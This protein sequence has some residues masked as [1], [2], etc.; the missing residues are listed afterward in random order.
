MFHHSQTVPAVPPGTRAPA[1]EELVEALSRPEAYPL[2]PASV[3]VLETH[4][5][6]LFFADQRVYKVKKAVDLGFLDH[7][8]LEKRRAACRDEVRLNGRLAPDVYLRVVPITRETD[9]RIV[10][11]GDGDLVEV[12]VEMNRLPAERML[13][14]LLD[15]G[16]I[17]SELVHEL[18]ELL[19]LFHLW[20]PTGLGVDEHGA[21]EAVRRLVLDNLDGL[22]PFVGGPGEEAPS[23]VPVLSA[24][25]HGWLRERAVAF[26]D[27][28]EV[29]MARRVEEGRIREGHGDL[30]AGN[31]CVLDDAIVAYDCLEFSRA[32]RCG[33]AACDLAFLAMDLDSR[34]FRAFSQQL[35]REYARIARDSDAA[36][37][38]DFYKTYRALVR[39]K[40]A[41]LSA[42]QRAPDDPEREVW[43]RKAV[44]SAQLAASYELPPALVL[45]CGLPATGKSTLARDLARPFEAVVLR[46]DVVRKQL[47]GMPPTDRPDAGET[48]K[49]YAPETSDEVHRRLLRRATAALERGRSV[50]VDATFGER[51]RRRRFVDAASRLGHPVVV[52]HVTAD[53]ATVRERLEARARDRRAV[54]DADWAVHQ[55]LLARFE[56]PDELPADALVE[57]TSPHDPDVARAALIER[58]LAQVRSRG[59][60]STAPLETLA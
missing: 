9:G 47:L 20:A 1:P 10:L 53:E 3:D 56:A 15:A 33:D 13:D 37:L 35:V 39:A 17:D 21:P 28:H 60:S 6:L 31:L 29:L 30:H 24:G 5:S 25:L 27:R 42:R 49:L 51:A 57:L 38:V 58:L 40:V 43:R 22:K 48:V 19:A 26:L 12:A 55:L 18:S 45:T 34:G 4:I 36:Y 14:R 32:L 54:S 8:S 11:D 7:T 16:H 50:V 23:G 46:S 52:V 59:P 41:G 44:A 2:P